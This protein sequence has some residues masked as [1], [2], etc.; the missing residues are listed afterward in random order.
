MSDCSEVCVARISGTG[1]VGS[2]ICDIRDLPSAIVEGARPHSCQCG[3][4]GVEAL[5]VAVVL[6]LDV[7]AGGFFVGNAAAVVF[8]AGA[9]QL[10]EAVGFGRFAIRLGDEASD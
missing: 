5:A 2:A 7:V 4:G 1:P 6:D 10:A 9:L 8:L 3:G